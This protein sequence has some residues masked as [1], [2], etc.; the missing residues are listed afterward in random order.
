VSFFKWF[1]WVGFL[2]PTLAAGQPGP[3]APA[4]ADCQLGEPRP[5]GERLHVRGRGGRPGH[6][7][8]GQ[9]PARRAITA[10]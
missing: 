8:S 2:L 4:A 10:R 5:R 1:F 7:Q 6:S 3:A 9:A